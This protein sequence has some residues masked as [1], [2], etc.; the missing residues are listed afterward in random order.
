VADVNERANHDLRVDVSIA[1]LQ[2]P[3]SALDTIAQG[4]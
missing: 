2:S 1:D 4:K 3:V